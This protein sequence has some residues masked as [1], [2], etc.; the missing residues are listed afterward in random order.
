VKGVL[1]AKLR[2][3]LS[4]DARIGTK[5]REIRSERIVEGLN[6][7]TTTSGRKGGSSRRDF[8]LSEAVSLPKFWASLD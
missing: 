1:I 5:Q 4:F 6:L 7:D 8:Q 3:V 2:T